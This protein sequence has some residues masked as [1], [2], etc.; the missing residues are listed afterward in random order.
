ME[1]SCD[2]NSGSRWHLDKGV[3]LTVI[4][5]LILQGIYFS[6]YMG[7]LETR[8]S[9]LEMDQAKDNA[10]REQFGRLDE[11]LKNMEKGVENLQ[12]QMGYLI[13]SIPYTQRR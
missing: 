7:K 6:V 5:A 1:Q 2:Q 9:S 10:V 12:S 8:V 3:N 4:I 11:R 13:E